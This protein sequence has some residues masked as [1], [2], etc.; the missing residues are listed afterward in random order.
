M[1]QALHCTSNWRASV[2]VLECSVSP[3][4]Q[5]L[6]SF[7]SLALCC[8]HS[9][10]WPFYPPRAMGHPR[11]LSTADFSLF[12]IFPS[13]CNIARCETDTYKVILV[14]NT[15]QQGMMMLLQTIQQ[16]EINIR[17]RLYIHISNDKHE[18]W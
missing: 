18:H 12:V 6:Q 3:Y 10:S 9:D 11:V 14:I 16:E 2:T 13:M 17:R 5:C 8:E 15:R 4:S 7:S 1:C